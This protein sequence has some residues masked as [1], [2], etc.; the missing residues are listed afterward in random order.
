MAPLL[1]AL[2]AL[3]LAEAHHL[4]LAAAAAIL[5]VHRLL[6]VALAHLL[7]LV[8]PERHRGGTL[9]T[10]AEGLGGEEGAWGLRRRAA[11][12]RT[13]DSIRFRIG[14]REGGGGCEVLRWGRF[15]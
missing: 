11:R 13:T 5:R 15:I 6:V 7:P 8:R 2:L 4:V 14:E 3:G 10:A 9:E 12:A 1:E